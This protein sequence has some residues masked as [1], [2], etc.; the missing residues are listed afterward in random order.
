M[1]NLIKSGDTEGCPA[2]IKVCQCEQC[3]AAR[4]KTKNRQLKRKV[5]RLLNKKRR[6]VIDKVL[7]YY[8]A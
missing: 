3:K 5:K 8:W 6:T 4:N 2:K 1:K 7:T